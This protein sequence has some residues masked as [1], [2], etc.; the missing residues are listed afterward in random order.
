MAQAE[1][2]TKKLTP[3]QAQFVK[4]FLVDLNGT[5]AARRAGY[6]A[7]TAEQQGYQLLQKTSVKKA[8]AKA[9]QARSERTEITADQVLKELALIGFSDMRDFTSW[10]PDG[11]KLEE[12][13]ELTEDQARAVA[14]VSET[15]TEHGGTVRFKLHDKRAS[16]VDIGR[17]LNMFTDNVNLSGGLTLTHEQALG[18]LK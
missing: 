8:V 5:A 18:Q 14:E 10:G 2:T 17:H 13:G 16:L 6:S 15:K 4:E 11:V 12:S 9:M 3:K 1:K 7:K